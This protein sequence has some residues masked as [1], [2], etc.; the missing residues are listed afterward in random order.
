MSV[1]DAELDNATAEQTML[2]GKICA[3]IVKKSYDKFLPKLYDG[4]KSAL[5]TKKQILNSHND[6]IKEATNLSEQISFEE[7]NNI[8]NINKNNIPNLNKNNVKYASKVE[9]QLH[10][11]PNDINRQFPFS[12][13]EIILKNG[14]VITKT[15]DKKSATGIYYLFQH[16]DTNSDGYFEVGV[17]PKEDKSGKLFYEID[18]RGY[19]GKSKI[20]DHENF[21][22]GLDAEIKQRRFENNTEINPWRKG[23]QNMKQS[24][25]LGAGLNAVFNI[26]LLF[27]GNV[28][29]FAAEVGIGAGYAALQSGAQDVLKNSLPQTAAEYAG[30]IAGVLLGTFTEVYGVCH[31]NDWARF[32]KNMTLH[33]AS[34]GGGVAGAKG[35]TILGSFFGPIGAGIGAVVGGIGGAITSRFVVGKIPVIGNETTREEI[36]RISNMTKQYRQKL[37]EQGTPVPDNISDQE[38]FKLIG[39]KTSI[40]KGNYSWDDISK[41]K[42]TTS[43]LLK[44]GMYRETMRLVFTWAK[45]RSPTGNITEGLKL[46]LEVDLK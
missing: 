5:N 10:K 45:F 18:H 37:R 21:L 15:D 35:G 44:P 3:K 46:M 42:I 4:I 14:R 6:A 33:T 2:F 41:G 19:R 13:D 20:S 9:N 31:H 32:G 29:G 28:G 36:K 17:C 43:T 27:N 38:L 16:N 7:N 39:E 30:P 26:D 24:V 12:F 22:K 25:L 8:S 23:I 11:H 34:V 1:T 40:V